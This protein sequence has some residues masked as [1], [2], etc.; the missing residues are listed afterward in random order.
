M[1]KIVAE[2]YAPLQAAINGTLSGPGTLA[3]VLLCE[4][5]LSFLPNCLT[6]G[7]PYSLLRAYELVPMSV[8]ESTKRLDLRKFAELKDGLLYVPTPKFEKVWVPLRN[9]PSSGKA[10]ATS[11]ITFL[12]KLHARR[13]S[14]DAVCKAG[15]IV[16]T[17][18]KYDLVDMKIVLSIDSFKK[19]KDDGCVFDVMTA[20]EYTDR[21]FD[22]QQL[23]SEMSTKSFLNMA[24]DLFDHAR[25]KA[26]IAARLAKEMPLVPRTTVH[27]RSITFSP[28][29]FTMITQGDMSSGGMTSGDAERMV[30]AA[31][32]LMRDYFSLTQNEIK[33]TVNTRPRLTRCV[34]NAVTA[35]RA[36]TTSTRHLL[37]VACVTAILLARDEKLLHGHVRFTRIYR[38]TNLSRFVKL[39][40]L[41]DIVRKADD[42]ELD[43]RDVRVVSTTNLITRRSTRGRRRTGNPSASQ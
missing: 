28:S 2:L 12:N 34:R 10:I 36:K 38:S 31:T 41:E 16:V 5:L 43:A 21:V 27:A 24:M 6:K 9:L 22:P 40:K 14:S 23:P 1:N 39:K 13:S 33:K 8:L 30:M 26:S 37:S 19:V 4:T 15:D 35:V 20:E 25:L 42:G 17:Q 11:M 3:T 18:F 29:A 32:P 7:Q